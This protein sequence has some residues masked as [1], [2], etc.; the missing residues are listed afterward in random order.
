MARKTRQQQIEF[1]HICFIDIA[2]VTFVA[3]CPC[4]KIRHI[5]IKARHGIMVKIISIYNM[6]WQRFII[7]AMKIKAAREAQI[8]AT[9]T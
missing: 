5:N 8:K 3:F 6:R 4:I 1:R 9:A 7:S 2:N